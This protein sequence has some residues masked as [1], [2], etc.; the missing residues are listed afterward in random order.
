MS[1]NPA[2]LSFLDFSDLALVWPDHELDL[3]KTWVML[4][5]RVA[6]GLKEKGII[7]IGCINGADVLAYLSYNSGY[8]I[9]PVKNKVTKLKINNQEVYSKLP[10][11][12]NALITLS[13]CEFSLG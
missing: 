3:N 5:K 12:K 8:F 6:L 13:D 1:L 11:D 7:D 10:I 9:E 2:P 4:G